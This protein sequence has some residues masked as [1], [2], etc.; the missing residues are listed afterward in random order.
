VH[1]FLV[2][3]QE[4]KEKFQLTGPQVMMFQCHG[5]VFVSV[6]RLLPPFVRLFY[7]PLWLL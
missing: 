7:I 3:D 2:G 4:K 1:I 5:M 6:E